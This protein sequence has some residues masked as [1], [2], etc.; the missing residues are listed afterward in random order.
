MIA[1]LRWC[2]RIGGLAALIFGLLLWRGMLPGSVNLHMTLGGIVAAALA[3]LAVYAIAT[4]V[5]VPLA[6]VGLLWAVATGYVGSMQ[7][8]WLPGSNHW[9]VSVIHL[10]LGIGAIGL[11]EAL[12]RR[13]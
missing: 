3:I 10:L 8:H 2:V 4:R 6:A 1:L 12:S 13:P 7:T 5:R 11:A 9:I